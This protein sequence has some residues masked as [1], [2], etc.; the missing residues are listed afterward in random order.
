MPFPRIRRCYVCAK[1]MTNAFCGVSFATTLFTHVARAA[2][3]FQPALAFEPMGVA[4]LLDCRVLVDFE[5]RANF[6][7]QSQTFR[8]VGG[9]W[10]DSPDFESTAWDVESPTIRGENRPRGLVARQ[11]HGRA[12]RQSGRAVP[13]LGREM[14]VRGKHR[15]AGTKR[16]G[17]VRHFILQGLSARAAQ[18]CI[19]ETQRI[20]RAEKPVS[21]IV[22]SFPR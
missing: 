2:Q 3:L 11:F 7:R 14:P 12:Q 21:T 13:Q 8:S 15:T 10:R 17:R 6:D 1:S 4:Q 5:A 9:W 22:V 19:P 20:H 18:P 16:R